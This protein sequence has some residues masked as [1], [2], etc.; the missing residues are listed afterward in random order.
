MIRILV[1]DDSTFMRDILKE[2]INKQ[3][4]MQVIGEADD[5]ISGFERY[6]ELH[7]DVVTLDIIMAR[8]N[9]I[10]ALQ[11]IL[12]Y[13]KNATVIMV[14]S[15]GQERYVKQCL[16]IGAKGF[17]IKPFTEEDVISTIKKAVT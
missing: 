2:I 10:S 16:D 8:E 17:V 6:K 1:V 9:G 14:T 13:D 4:N 3:S 15:V 11:K 12:E 5:G 7:P